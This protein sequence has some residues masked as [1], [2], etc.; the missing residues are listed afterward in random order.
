M[1]K[2]SLTLPFNG[3]KLRVLREKAGLNVE[4]FAAAIADDDYSV[5]RTTIGKIERG[6]YKPSAPL[7]KALVTTLNR[8]AGKK[9]KVTIDD[10]LDEDAEPVRAVA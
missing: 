8:L 3:G 1:P 6:D 5:H 10:L 7:L 2:Q 9:V 4:Q